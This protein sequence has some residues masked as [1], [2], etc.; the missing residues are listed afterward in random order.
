MVLDY[1]PFGLKHKGYNNVVNS[2]NI[3]Q[4]YKYN[5]KELNEEL[6][7]D[8]YDYGWRNY[9]AS[10]GR[11]MNIDPLAEKYYEFSTYNYVKNN[12]IYFVDP[13]GMEIY[14]HRGRN[15]NDEQYEEFKN[16][17]LADLQK[18][19]DNTL[20]IDE[21]GKVIEIE[22]GGT[23]T[24]NEAS[25]VVS[26]L[27]YDDSR[28][29]IFKSKGKNVT[30]PGKGS[31]LKEDGTPGKGSDFVRINYDPNLREGGLDVNGSYDRDPY[32]GLAH[33]L[34]H[35]F[36]AINGTR[37]KSKSTMKDPDEPERDKA[38][39][40]TKKEVKARKFENKIR[41][42]QGLPLRK[43]GKEKTK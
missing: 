40:L 10:I 39:T 29:N 13:D 8:W 16:Q 4:K 21:N 7:L 22:C 1:Y 5:G 6:G 32:I 41:Q 25:S 15:M 28:I 43:L 20:E 35:A 23:E 17:V 2:T 14:I 12:P 33:E 26:K 3:A 30:I 27:I 18:L 11:W 34:G 42:E 36:D 38:K 31:D 19:S 9:D 37:D 24:C